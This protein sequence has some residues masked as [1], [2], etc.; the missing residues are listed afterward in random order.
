MRV[1]HTIPPQHVLY[2]L[3][4]IFS[5]LMGGPKQSEFCK[6]WVKLTLSWPIT[7]PCRHVP[8]PL[9]C[10][11]SQQVTSILKCVCSPGL[12]LSE[13]F[14]SY[15]FYITTKITSLGLCGGCIIFVFF[16][17]FLPYFSVFFKTN[18]GGR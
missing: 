12:E 9:L 17:F 5:Y 2:K 6:V 11:K 3:K 18:C 10:H 16:C 8:I 4:Y 15:N 13:A 1:I 14:G 7:Q